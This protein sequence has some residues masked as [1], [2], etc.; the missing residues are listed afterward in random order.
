MICVLKYYGILRTVTHTRILI[1]WNHLSDL[2]Y[3]RAISY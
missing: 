1:V 2:G 3:F